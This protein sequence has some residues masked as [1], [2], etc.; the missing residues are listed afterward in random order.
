MSDDAGH[1]AHFLRRIDRLNPNHAE[2]ALGLYNDDDLVR[3]LLSTTLL[4]AEAD[5]VAI[6][7]DDEG[8]GPFIIV[9]REGKFVTC[10]GKGM[11]LPQGQ[12]VFSRRSVDKSNERM[13]DVRALFVKAQ[14][15]GRHGVRSLMTR[16]LGAGPAL[17]REEFDDL[18]TWTP[19]IRDIYLDTLVKA[20]GCV[21]P[22]YQELSRLKN[23]GKKHEEVLQAYWQSLWAV[24]HL[25]L[26]VAEDPVL[27][28]SVFDAGVRGA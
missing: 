18:S 16:V 2:L 15:K 22:L 14:E 4:P 27:L 10:L 19:V 9:T 6:A 7:L 17:T 1:A 8:Q 13:T 23:V 28:P 26:L 5:R 20:M 12:V 11:K 3:Y 21:T 24:S 25:T